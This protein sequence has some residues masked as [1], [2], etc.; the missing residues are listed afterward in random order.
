MNIVFFGSDN[1]AVQP[2]LALL[3]SGHRILSVVTQPDKRKG[4]GLKLTGETA[5]KEAALSAGIKVYQPEDINSPDALE[6]LKSQSADLF[7]VVAYGQILSQQV[8]DIP[9]YLSINAHASLL[10]KYR[11]A[12]PISRAIICGETQTGISIIKMTPVLDAGPVMLQKVIPISAE[13]SNL[14]LEGRLRH[15]AAEVLV[16]A[17]GSIKSGSYKLTP[18]D[19]TRI[20]VAPKLKKKDGLIN[21]QQD[22]FTIHN[23]IRGS[24]GWPGA[25]TYS[26]GKSVKVFRA[27]PLPGYVHNRRPG[28]VLEAGKQGITVASGS[29]ALVI[30]E[31][32]LEGKLR[33]SAANFISGCKI[34]P[35]EMLG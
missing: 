12:S 13:D 17:I 32:Q 16:E 26:R 29:G 31:L 7:V 4:R 34:G 3:A 6:F 20:T 21:W 2:L 35:G 18:Q 33:M 9:R 30:E 15:L 22:A 27:H 23:L 14:T 8:L 10:P 11:G 5:V 19:K 24:L 25:F 28:E 1:F